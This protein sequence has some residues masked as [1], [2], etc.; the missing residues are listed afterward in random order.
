MIPVVN[1]DWLGAFFID[2]VDLELSR[3]P[4]AS[5]SEMLGLNVCATTPSHE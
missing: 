5:A 4:P 3:D 1:P 2:Q